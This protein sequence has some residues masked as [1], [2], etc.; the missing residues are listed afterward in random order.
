VSETSEKEIR[1][2][3]GEEEYLDDNARFIGEVMSG[4][5]EDIAQR[6]ESPTSVLE[7]FLLKEASMY[8][9]YKEY[10][11]YLM[12]E[13]DGK[14]DE[15]NQWQGEDS[16]QLTK[17][18]LD[19]LACEDS[20]MKELNAQTSLVGAG[21]KMIDEE[22][23]EN[24]QIVLSR[25]RSSGKE[26]SEKSYMYLVVYPPEVKNGQKV[27]EREVSFPTAM[28]H[29]L[30]AVALLDESAVARILDRTDPS[31]EAFEPKKVQV[32][33]NDY[34]MRLLRIKPLS[35]EE[36]GE[37]I[38][39]HGRTVGDK[40]AQAG[41]T[42]IDKLQGRKGEHVDALSALRD[43]EYALSYALACHRGVGE[44][45]NN[46]ITLPPVVEDKA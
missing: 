1:I 30:S 17:R 8:P 11:A 2:V 14:F 36:L 20:I 10:C 27:R 38:T 6:A 31:E 25:D 46:K 13:V 32:G 3:F 29:A 15:D 33:D 39:T 22:D 34:T 16:Q 19:W 43:Q 9:H 21:M 44:V 41:L 26:Y 23:E 45:V 40:L 7:A 4:V 24:I 12:E 28:C 42:I 35:D 5:A 18:I 37:V